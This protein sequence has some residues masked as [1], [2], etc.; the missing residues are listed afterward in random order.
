VSGDLQAVLF[1]LDGTL[2]RTF[3]DFPA[4]RHAI[5]Q[6]ARDR[7]QATSTVLQNSDSLDIIRQ[8]LEALPPEQRDE[9]R[10]DLYTILEEHEEIGCAHP[11]TIPCATELLSELRGRGC[12]LGIVT[13][14]ARRIAASLWPAHKD[15]RPCDRRP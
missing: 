3:I 1:D 10:R 6:C 7:Y 12:G 11:E 13:R 9:A 8:T 15:R 14:N 4:M 2:V 5:Q